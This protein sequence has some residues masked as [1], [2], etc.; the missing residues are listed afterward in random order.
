V[1]FSGKQLVGKL[2]STGGKWKTI[3][4]E[5]KLPADV[6]LVGLH[7]DGTENYNGDFYI[8]AVKIYKLKNGEKTLYRSYSFEKNEFDGS[9]FPADWVTK[10]SSYKIVHVDP[11]HKYHGKSIDSLIM[12]TMGKR[13]VFSFIP[14]TGKYFFIPIVP[15][16]KSS[17]KEKFAKVINANAY[18]NSKDIHATIDKYYRNFPYANNGFGTSVGNTFFICNNEVNSKSSKKIH[19]DFFSI[20]IDG[21]FWSHNYLVGTKIRNGYRFQLNNYVNYLSDIKLVFKRPVSS[22]KAPDNFNFTLKGNTMHIRQ[23]HKLPTCIDFR[24]QLE[25]D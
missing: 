21:N 1:N 16:L 4:K 9:H 11:K 20:A 2:V 12:Y 24:V 14:D 5:L 17:E 8:D 13:Q 10:E 25:G 7:I 22:V 18:D 23:L 6:Y 15:G 3:K 19:A